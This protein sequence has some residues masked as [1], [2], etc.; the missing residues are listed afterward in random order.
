MWDVASGRRLMNWRQEYGR[1]ASDVLSPDGRSVL[2]G[3]TVTA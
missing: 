3:T 2:A 1:L